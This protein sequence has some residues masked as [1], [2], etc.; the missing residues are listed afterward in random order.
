MNSPATTKTP[1]SSKPIYMIGDPKFSNPSKGIAP[2]PLE[3]IGHIRNLDILTNP[4]SVRL[5]NLTTKQSSTTV[6]GQ[7]LWQ[8]VHAAT[9]KVYAIDGNGIVYTALNTGGTWTVIG[10]AT[11]SGNNNTANAGQGLE[12]WKDYV[13]TIGSSGFDAYDINGTTWHNNF[14]STAHDGSPTYRPMLWSID[15]SLYIGNSRYVSRLQEVTTFDPTSSGTY[16]FTQQAITLAT[17]Y[18]V[19]SIRD[20]G[21]NLMLGTVYL[22]SRTL[23]DIF[24]YARTTLT[25]GIP[26][27]IVENG[28]QAMYNLGN[29]LYVLAGLSG[30][31]FVTDTVSATQIAQIPNYIINLDANSALQMY[32]DA[33][34]YM[35]GKIWF[36][37]GN[38]TLGNAGVWSYDV[39]R[40]VLQMENIISLGTDGSANSVYI[41][42]LQPFLSNNTYLMAW[43]DGASSSFGVDM[44]N[45]SQRYTGYLGYIDSPLVKVGEALANMTTPQLEIN[46]TK[47][48]VTG[49]GVK[50]Q[51]RKDLTSAWT[52]LSTADF[53]TLG[54]YQATNISAS[55]MTSLVFLQIRAL[56]TT[57]GSSN[58]SPELQSVLLVN[59]T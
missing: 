41:S 23:A 30:K 58:L 51:Y 11:G 31:L 47:P 32:P 2:H 36:G 5:N 57:A 53:A 46:L 9:G 42:S 28:V 49:Q 34:M 20:L 37:I 8:R 26:I 55:V 4:G 40:K 21:S 3:G 59:P 17:N 33:I 6:T 15:D 1:A 38:S 14:G 27:R 12:V 19:R 48:L 29:R 13:I 39:T 18:E 50:I 16:T 56:L 43:S 45:S 25:L 10:N 35:R 52:T 22:G 44:I 54:G 24:P 7:I